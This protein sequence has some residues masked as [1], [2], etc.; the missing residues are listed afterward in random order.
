MLQLEEDK[1]LKKIEETRRKARIIMDVRLNKAAKVRHNSR[2]PR[3]LTPDDNRASIYMERKEEHKRVMHERLSL[4][5]EHRREEAMQVKKERKAISRRKLQIER[6][7]TRA[8][9]LRRNEIVI[10]AKE[11]QEKIER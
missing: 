7:Y 9:Q 3:S 11:G 8:N 6:A 2:E 10:Q 4:I 5:L 1:A